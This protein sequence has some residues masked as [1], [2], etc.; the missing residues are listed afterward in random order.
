[1]PS[2]VIAFI[3]ILHVGGKNRLFFLDD[4]ELLAIL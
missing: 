4:V 1:V 3:N 2:L